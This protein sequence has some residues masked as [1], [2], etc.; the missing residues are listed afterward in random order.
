M[1]YIAKPTP[2]VRQRKPLKSRPHVIPAYIKAAVF[3]LYGWTCQ[4]CE[5]PGGGLDP[6]HILP[7]SRGGT[8]VYGNLKPVHRK[9]HRYIHEH[10]TEARA[11]D[12]IR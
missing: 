8:D 7:R 2:K 10:P 1:T 5:Q 6:H 12:F 9:C 4:W 11:R 3:Q